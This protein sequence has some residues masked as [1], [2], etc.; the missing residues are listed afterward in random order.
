MW[1]GGWA[2]RCLVELG[3][4]QDVGGE[5][6]VRCV[7]LSGL[8]DARPSASSSLGM[9][10]VFFKQCIAPPACKFLY[11]HHEKRDLLHPAKGT[12]IELCAYD[13]ILCEV[14]VV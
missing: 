2:A 7:F 10:T 6:K 11:L 4:G 5:L 13:P 1:T 12:T 8:C 3:L 9:V 14:I